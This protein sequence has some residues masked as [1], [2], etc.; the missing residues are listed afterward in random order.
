MKTMNEEEMKIVD[1]RVI[2]YVSSFYLNVN[3]WFNEFENIQIFNSNL[4]AQLGKLY[5]FILMTN[6]FF[7]IYYFVMTYAFNFKFIYNFIFLCLHQFINHI[8]CCIFK[9]TILL[10]EN[11]AKK[12]IEAV[13]SP[14]EQ[15]ILKNN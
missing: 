3:D 12:F 7:R 6:A 8:F 14:L 2:C 1:T 15:L 11:W 5:D 4:Q 13:K 10:G 9:L